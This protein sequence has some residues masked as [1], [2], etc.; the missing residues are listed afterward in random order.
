MR[1][2]IPPAAGYNISE[3]ETIRVVLP[4]ALVAS[5]RT[6]SWLPP[7]VAKPDEAIWTDM[8]V[9]SNLLPRVGVVS[10]QE[11]RTNATHASISFKITLTHEGSGTR[12]TNP[13]W[14]QHKSE[15]TRARNCRCPPKIPLNDSSS[16]KY[17]LLKLMP[18]VA[19]E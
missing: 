11:L 9:E 13:D 10:E 4:G 2:T 7:L 17:H 5:N 14:L 8:E 3:P 18:V 15:W 1:L 6:Y 19:V 16:Q 12:P